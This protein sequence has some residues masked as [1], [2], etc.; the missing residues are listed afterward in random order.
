MLPYAETL[1]KCPGYVPL[2]S[3][4]TSNGFGLWRDGG[5]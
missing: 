1:N 4:F 3:A 5:R 2:H